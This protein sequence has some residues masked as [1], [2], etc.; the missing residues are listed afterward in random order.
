MKIRQIKASEILDSRG[1]PTVEAQVILEDQSIG[2]SSSP[3]G[4]LLSTN[5]EAYELR[6]NDSKRFGGMGVLKAVDNINNIIAPKL[7]GLEVQQQNNIDQTLINLDGTPNKTNLGGNAILAVS[8]AVVKAASISYKMPVYAYIKHKYE[9]TTDSIPTPIFNVINGG[10]H[11]AGNLDFQ[12]FHLIPSKR[13]AYHI[14]LECGQEIYQSLKNVLTYRGAIHSVGEEGGFA[15]NLFTNID[16]LEVIL[17]A[18]K[19]TNY[20]LN[21]DVF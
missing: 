4:A 17:E 14:A 10:K 7:I 20:Q 2:I 5:H 8:Q 15:P 6:D 11:G 16:A 19:G 13:L 21:K 18:I 3:S 1:I 9:T 12:E